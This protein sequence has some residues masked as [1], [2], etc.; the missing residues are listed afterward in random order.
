MSCDG[1][2]V[3]MH[4]KISTL[5]TYI[6]ASACGS[7]NGK[8]KRRQRDGGNGAGAERPSRNRRRKARR[9]FGHTRNGSRRRLWATIARPCIMP[10][11]NGHL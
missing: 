10:T 8:G 5:I 6:K 1:I 7:A 2:E 3:D 11:R 4:I 9:S